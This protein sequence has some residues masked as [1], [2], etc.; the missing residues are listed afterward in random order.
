MKTIK[1]VFFCS[2]LFLLSSGA[3]FCELSKAQTYPSKTIKI[4]VSTAA[5]G[6]PDVIA[7][8]IA[9]KLKNILHQ[10]V[11]VENKPGATG[12]ISAVMVANSAADGYTLLYYDSPIWAINPH[13][14]QK[15]PYDPFKDLMPV[16]QTHLAPLF[17]V[18]PTA[19]QINTV[20]QLIEYARKNPGKVSYA[21]AGIGSSHHLTAE[22][23]RSL[24]NI[25]IVHVPYKGGAPASVALSAGEVEMGFLSYPLAVAGVQSGK[26]KILGIGTAQR[27]SSFPDIPSIAESG[28]PGFDI[29]TTLGFLAPAGTPADVVFKLS[30]AISVAIHEPDIKELVTSYGISLAPKI[31]PAQFGVV[32]RAEYEKFGQIVKSS[33]A[34]MD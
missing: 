16:A 32:M 7:R 10:S 24:A 29:Y 27:A 4:I 25:S 26:T 5:G 31:T 8:R 1:R 30:E 15:L 22:Q 28:L 21:S 19:L 9:D 11:V 20:A 17:L 2:I 13:L 34:R 23:F 6:A 12:N 18:V 3:L 14:Y 33:G